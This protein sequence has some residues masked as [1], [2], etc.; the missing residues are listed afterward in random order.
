MAE[1]LELLA[2]LHEVVDLA[3]IDERGNDAA[4]FLGLHGLHA[5]GEV[6][7]GKAAMPQAD[8]PIDEHAFRIRAAER[9]RFRH[10]RD[11]VP[12]RLDIAF[13]AHPTGYSAHSRDLSCSLPHASEIGRRSLDVVSP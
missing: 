7:D 3:G 12:L 6:D 2:Q 8:M 11:N 5:A 13:V 9:H 4:L 10:R 1:A